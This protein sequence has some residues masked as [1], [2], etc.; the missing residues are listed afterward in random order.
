M[1]AFLPPQNLVFFADEACISQDRFTVVGGV[2][3]HRNNI[4]IVRKNLS[5]YRNKFNMTSELKWS[6]ISNQKI[7]EYKALVDYF[8]WL[9][10]SDIVHFHSLIFDSH[11]ANHGRFNNGCRDTGLSKLYYQLILHKFGGRYPDTDMAVCLDHRNSKTP[12]EDL[13]RMLNAGVSKKFG[14][15]KAPIKQ[16]VS[17]DSKKDDILQMNDVILGAV[18]AVRNGK[19]ELVGG[20]AAKMELA[21]YVLQKSGLNG[22]EVDSPR[23]VTRF[24]V[25]NFRGNLG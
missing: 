6:K 11:K 12:H 7:E 16:V 15:D 25:W 9:N 22:F 2:C 21:K 24:T 10:S 3:I 5:A 4:P 14:I 19:H 17:A 8:F 1:S 13:R 20:R 23:R 18:G